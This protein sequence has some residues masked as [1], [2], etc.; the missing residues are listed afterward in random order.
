MSHQKEYRSTVHHYLRA[1]T[2]CAEL[3]RNGIAY[4]ALKIKF[5]SAF[6][7]S[8]RNEI[9]TVTTNLNENNYQAELE[10]LLNRDSIYD[11][12]P[13]G[14]FHQTRGNSKT[15]NVKEMSEE[16]RRFKEEEKHARKFFQP[17]E[18]E[19]F[20]YATMVEKEEVDF[21]FGM[22]NGNVKNELQQFWNIPDGL[23]AH[24]V[25]KLVQI[26]PWANFIKGDAQLTAKAL[27]L[28]LEKPVLFESF[29]A[30][31]QVAGNT[32]FKLGV[33]ELGIGTVTGNQFDEP[34]ACWKFSIGDLSKDE[35]ALF[36]PANAYGRLLNHFE[37]I[38]IPLT[39]DIIFE[40]ACIENA[41]E[42][43]ADVLGFSMVL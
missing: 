31:R 17:L 36:T 35:I 7:K 15:S 32:A 34:V 6:R 22:L 10:L 19:F 26:L 29:T 27:E 30:F 41:D 20:R 40:F 18:Q 25:R 16:H 13:D 33:S 11:R 43:T 4:E 8:F 37:K 5:G 1:E 24:C 14:I 2:F 21:S 23:P 39:I 9:E 42:E 12:L 3:T 28:V 38:M